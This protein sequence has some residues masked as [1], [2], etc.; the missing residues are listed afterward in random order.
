MKDVNILDFDP[1]NISDNC[2]LTKEDPQ[3]ST[4]FSMYLQLQ[5]ML[6]ETILVNNKLKI[7]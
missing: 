1:Y 5:T 2:S 7:L 6:W 3:F 4:L